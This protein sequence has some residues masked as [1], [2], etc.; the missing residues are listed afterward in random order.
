MAGV[1]VANKI[2]AVIFAVLVGYGIDA[3]VLHGAD[4][5]IATDTA[6]MQVTSADLAAAGQYGI[7]GAAPGYTGQSTAPA[8]TLTGGAVV[9]KDVVLM[10]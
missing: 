7:F 6:Q 4:Y 3:D 9:T 10:P 2:F 8:L 1:T 5:R